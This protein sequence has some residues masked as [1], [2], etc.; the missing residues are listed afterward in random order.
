M[1]ELLSWLRSF[2]NLP[3]TATAEEILAELNK[4]SAQLQTAINNGTV[5]AKTVLAYLS[6]NQPVLVTAKQTLGFQQQVIAKLGLAADATPEQALALI[7]T[8]KASEQQLALLNTQVQ[9]LTNERFDERFGLVIATGRKDGRILPTQ[10]KDQNWLEQQKA[11]AQKNFGSFETYYCKTGP[12]IGPV[13]PLPNNDT[14]AQANGLTDTDKEVAMLLGVPEA[15]L[16]KHNPV[17]K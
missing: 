6:E 14:A 3:L 11:W 13:G 5:T 2:M 17:Q 10:E 9:Q 16:A 15:V 12:V 8:A 7:V 1:D 4:L